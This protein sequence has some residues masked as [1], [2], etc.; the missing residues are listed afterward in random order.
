MG[1]GHLWGKKE[2]ALPVSAIDR[3]FDEVVY[4]KLDKQSIE[5]LPAI[6]VR[7]TLGRSEAEIELVAVVFDSPDGAKEALKFL[8]QLGLIG[9]RNA[10]TR[11]VDR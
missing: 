6:P 5:K 8:K 4:L 2:L 11:I 1:E 10:R 7:R 3:V 9:K